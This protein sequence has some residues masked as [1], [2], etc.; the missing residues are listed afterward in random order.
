MR[1]PA[2][3]Q[4]VDVIQRLAPKLLGGQVEGKAAHHIEAVYAAVGERNA[5]DF[6]AETVC[7]VCRDEWLFEIEIDPAKGGRFI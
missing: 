3:G 7:D 5:E 6:A 4:N 1:F 2:L